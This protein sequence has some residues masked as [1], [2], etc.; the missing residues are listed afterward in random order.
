MTG[1]RRPHR[2]AAMPAR[3]VHAAL[4]AA[5]ATAAL[6]APA[7]HAATKTVYAG[8]PVAKA[9]ALPPD[10]TGNAFYPRKVAVNAGG[11]VAFKIGGLHNVIFAAAN[12]TP[13]SAFHAPDPGRPVAGVKDPAGSVLWFNGQPG[14]F[15]EPAHVIPFGDKS[16]DGE[17]LDASGVFQGQ[18]APPDYVVSFPKAGRYRYVCSIHPGMKGT[19]KVLPRKAKAPSKAKDAKTVAK[20]VGA[21]IKSATKL[22]AQAPAGNVVRAGNDRKEVAFFSF[23]P[24]SRQVKAGETVRFEMSKD[25]T[26]IHNVVF[27]PE[28]FLAETAAKFISPGAQGIAYDPL[29][30]YAS[31]PGALAYDGANHGN[32]FLNTGLLDTDPRTSFPAAKSVTFTKAGT[33]GFICTVHGPSM[34][35]SIEVS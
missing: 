26:E 13:L 9:K 17:E 22:A 28:P 15:I 29:S 11:K 35:G 34:K 33:Y 30:V 19:V 5:A 27:G 4:A 10:S 16:V 14:W 1:A 8:P 31:D 2:L 7:A 18:G 24:A 23:F 25:S 20:Q 32:G 21:T 6:L 3:H 12:G